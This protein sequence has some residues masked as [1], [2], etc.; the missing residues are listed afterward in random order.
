MRA[1]LSIKKGIL[2]LGGKKKT[3]KQVDFYLQLIT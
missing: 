3:N 2:Q 1:R